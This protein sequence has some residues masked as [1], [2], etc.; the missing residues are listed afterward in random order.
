MSLRPPILLPA[1]SR[2]R[3]GAIASQSSSCSAARRSRGWNAPQGAA[4]LHPDR[5]LCNVLKLAS[6]SP[7]SP[8]SFRLPF[9]NGRS[10][11]ETARGLAL[12]K[13]LW[14]GRVPER[15]WTSGCVLPVRPAPVRR[16]LRGGFRKERTS[17]ALSPASTWGPDPRVKGAILKRERGRDGP[18]PPSYYW[19]RRPQDGTWPRT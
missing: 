1:P 2:G 13:P 15:G 4:L 6:S 17:G 8:A 16:W 12:A 5:K 7:Q 14:E 19:C 9:R 3:L 18:A 10:E 11:M